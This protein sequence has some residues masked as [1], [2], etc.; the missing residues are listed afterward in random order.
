MICREQDVFRDWCQKNPEEN[1]IE[2]DYQSSQGVVDLGSHSGLFNSLNFQWDTSKEAIVMF[3]V[4]CIGTEFTSKRHDGEK[5]VPFQLQVHF[6][7]VHH[8]SE[9]TG[10]RGGCLRVGRVGPWFESSYLKT[11]FIRAC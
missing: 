1:V 11:F 4:N 3:R 9:I 8:S 6:N 2:V 7:F 10:C 5:G